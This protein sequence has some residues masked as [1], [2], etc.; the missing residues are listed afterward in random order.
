ME[1][2]VTHEGGGGG[3]TTTK[4]SHNLKIQINIYY[5]VSYVNKYV[6]K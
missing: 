3:L 4:E 2:L 6:F 5:L 1:I